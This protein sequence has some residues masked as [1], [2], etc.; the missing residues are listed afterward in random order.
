MVFSGF[1]V[2]SLKLVKNG[3]VFFS[4]LEV[5]S[6]ILKVLFEGE[7]V[8]TDDSELR[9]LKRSIKSLSYPARALPFNFDFE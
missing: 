8:G 6:W 1:E 2:L 9:K 7:S 4:V 3:P 5:T